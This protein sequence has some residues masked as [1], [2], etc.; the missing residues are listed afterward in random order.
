MN[1]SDRKKLAASKVASAENKD[2]KNDA[3]AN[4]AEFKQTDGSIYDLKC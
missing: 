1:G 4:N 3:D 2:N